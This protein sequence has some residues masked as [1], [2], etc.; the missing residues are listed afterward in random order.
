VSYLP[1]NFPLGSLLLPPI[2]QISGTPAYHYVIMQVISSK[3]AAPCIYSALLSPTFS[4]ILV[5]VPAPLFTTNVAA[6]TPC[7][8]G[9]HESSSYHA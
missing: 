6:A 4:I 7:A 1:L 8:V 3:N 2:H 9:H 5:F